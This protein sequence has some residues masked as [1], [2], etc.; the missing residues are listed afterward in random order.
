MEGEQTKGGPRKPRSATLSYRN[1]DEFLLDPT[2]N[3]HDGGNSVCIQGW[4]R[5]ELSTRPTFGKPFVYALKLRRGR[6]TLFSGTGVGIGIWNLGFER[7]RLSATTD[8][9]C[10]ILV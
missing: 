4:R 9:V 1:I 6:K 5:F 7:R 8:P 2:I 3:V 10:N